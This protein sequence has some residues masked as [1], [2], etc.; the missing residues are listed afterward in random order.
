MSNLDAEVCM[1][2][3]HSTPTAAPVIM[4]ALPDNPFREGHTWPV[5]YQHSSIFYHIYSHLPLCSVG[6]ER[7][8]FPLR[9]YFRS[10][11]QN[12]RHI[13]NLN[14]KMNL[15]PRQMQTDSLDS[16]SLYTHTFWNVEMTKSVLSNFLV[17]ICLQS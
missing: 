8:R 1:L 14:I 9:N 4:S 17:N 5:L 13:Q 10:K 7:L 11:R 2:S 16:H 12:R 6:A 15:C 3:S